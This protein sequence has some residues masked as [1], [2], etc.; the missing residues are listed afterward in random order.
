MS[1]SR[2]S[3]LNFCLSATSSGDSPHPVHCHRCGRSRIRVRLSPLSVMKRS[4]PSPVK[5]S[6]SR[7]SVP[8]R[9][10]SCGR[11]QYLFGLK[12][13]RILPPWC[14]ICWCG[15]HST[16]GSSAGALRLWPRSSG[17][18]SQGKLRRRC[19]Y[20]SVMGKMGSMTGSADSAM[21]VGVA[22]GFRNFDLFECTRCEVDLYLDP[23][24]IV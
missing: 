16:N 5:A 1:C 17:G 15:S 24:A 19:W 3:I 13:G 10:P 11:T 9:F 7:P 18:G 8:G 20:C 21:T 4:A 2:K 22:L 14:Q 12:C 23:L 6:F